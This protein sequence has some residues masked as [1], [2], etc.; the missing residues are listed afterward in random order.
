MISIVIPNYN[1]ATYLKK[2]LDSLASCADLPKHEIIIVD[3]GSTD[4]SQD[5]AKIKNKTNLG[6]ATAINQGVSLAKYD[7]VLALNNDITFHKNY[8]KEIGPYLNTNYAAIA[9]QVLS[10]DGK[11]VESLGLKYYNYGKCHN[12]SNGQLYKPATNSQTRTVWGL[13][14]ACTFYNKEILKKVGGFDERFFAYEEDV[15]LAY[16]LSKLGYN[17]LLVPTAICYHIGGATSSKMGYF[18]QKHDFKNWILLIIK[19]YSLSDII[20]NSPEI[21]IER[22]RNLSGLAKAMFK[23]YFSRK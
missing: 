11:K 21:F 1:G 3:N 13:N 15:D 4:G 19:N 16:R 20:Q 23:Y 5:Q 18:R 9:G 12:I 14:A 10:H 2:C 8:F 17:S 22:G 6:F 7:W